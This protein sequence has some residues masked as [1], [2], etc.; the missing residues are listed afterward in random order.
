MNP[1]VS[2]MASSAGRITRIAAGIALIAWG[3][4]GLDGNTGIVVAII[5][6]LPLLAGLFDFCVFAPLFGCPLSGAK[7]RASS[8]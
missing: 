4:M 1:F 5:G 3:I 6:A 7:I 2:F 8:K